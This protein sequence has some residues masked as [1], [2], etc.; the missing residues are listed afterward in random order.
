MSMTAR[1]KLCYFNSMSYRTVANSTLRSQTEA[2]GRS[3][4]ALT[5]LLF[6]EQRPAGL[7]RLATVHPTFSIVAER[8][9]QAM[10]GEGES[11]G[12]RRVLRNKLL[13]SICRYEGQCRCCK[14]DV[15]V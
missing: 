4:T 5:I 2:G 10:R 7:H 15:Q 8:V 3:Q 14:P 13:H 6:D 12:C 9:S 1:H 11:S